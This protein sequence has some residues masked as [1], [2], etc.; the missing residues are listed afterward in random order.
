MLI[1][2]EEYGFSFV[3]PDD[4]REIPKEKY[5]EYNIDSSTL[6]V[7]VKVKDNEPYTI[8]LNRDDS[9]ENE[10]EYSE[11]LYCN[12]KNMETI[13]MKIEERTFKTDGRARVDTFY[14]RFRGLRFATRFTVI[15]GIMVA[16]SV[17]IKE[18]GDENDLILAA[19][20]DSIEEI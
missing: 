4:Y 13:G 18:K 19:L 17:E 9:V 11:L 8:S 7:F 3:V 15:R 20:Y 5:G 10:Q 6:H 2:N 14:S 1:R 16:C 12:A